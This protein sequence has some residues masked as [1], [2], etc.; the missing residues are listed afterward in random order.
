MHVCGVEEAGYCCVCWDILLR[1]RGFVEGADEYWNGEFLVTGEFKLSD[2]LSD[3]LWEH[4][5]I[6]H[7]D[8]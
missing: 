3:L 7:D 2:E 8:T 6:H 4:R 1:G 5:K